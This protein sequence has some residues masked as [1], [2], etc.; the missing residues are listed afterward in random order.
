MQYNNYSL[1]SEVLIDIF[2]DITS[3][4]MF[5]FIDMKYSCAVDIESDIFCDSFNWENIGPRSCATA[6]QQKERGP[7]CGPAVLSKLG[8]YEVHYMTEKM[9]SSDWEPT[10]EPGEYLCPRLK[11][12]K[13]K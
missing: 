9:L 8:L 1:H 13:K 7:I 5:N 10:T 6:L 2:G 11:K 4:L 3:I 12:Q